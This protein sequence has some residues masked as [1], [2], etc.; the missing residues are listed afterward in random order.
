[1]HNVHRYLAVMAVAVFSFSV[2]SQPRMK[3]QAKAA[4]AST[5]QNVPANIQTNC[6]GAPALPDI[7]LARLYVNKP[8]KPVPGAT[9]TV[10]ALLENRGQCETGAFTVQISVYVQ[11]PGRPDVD[12]M[13]LTKTI[14]SMQPTK[15]REPA[16]ISVA[17]DYT[18]GAEST[19]TYNFYASADPE[20]RIHEF[21]E[22]NNTVERN[23]GGAETFI[24]VMN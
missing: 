2:F 21:I 19:A 5:R 17:V 3:L 16:Y 12:K 24:N 6:A 4:S 9:Y 8:P 11:V 15:D 13:I 14:P 18:L 23:A 10:S 20:N 1:M 22:N 7:V